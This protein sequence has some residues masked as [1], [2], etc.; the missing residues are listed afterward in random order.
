MFLVSLSQGFA[1]CYR[2]RINQ[3]LPALFNRL[4]GT[5]L[6]LAGHYK[7]HPNKDMERLIRER[8]ARIKPDIDRIIKDFEKTE[9][10]R[11][12]PQIWQDLYSVEWD[13]REVWKESGLQISEKDKTELSDW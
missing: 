11:I 2:A 3:D 5:S 13:L 7:R 1:D 12:P 4:E 9:T 6:L 10:Y 8:L